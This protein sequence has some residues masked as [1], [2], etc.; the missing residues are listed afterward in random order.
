[1]DDFDQSQNGMF[2][3]AGTILVIVVV[4]MALKLGASAL[5]DPTG[6][7]I[8]TTMTT[9][10]PTTSIIKTSTSV[11]GSTVKPTSSTISASSS[12]TTPN[13][14]CSYSK[15]QICDGNVLKSEE[16]TKNGV[17]GTEACS[18]TVIQNCDNAY[19]EAGGGT[20]CEYYTSTN[21][22][23]CYG[24]VDINITVKKAMCIPTVCGA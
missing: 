13:L 20:C 12:T 17:A 21:S 7:F 19:S 2:I 3:A 16:C 11:T 24:M 23:T 9:T 22:S 5:T 4:L 6:N 1:M 10:A 18:K 14:V 8:G 15:G